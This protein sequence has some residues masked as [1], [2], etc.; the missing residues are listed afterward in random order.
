[1]HWK[2][3]LVAVW[4]L[5]KCP[6]CSTDLLLRHEKHVDSGNSSRRKKSGGKERA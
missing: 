5:V 1:M 2:E 3:D 4:I 6:S